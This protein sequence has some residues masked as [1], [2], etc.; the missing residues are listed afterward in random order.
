MIRL[1]TVKDS[2]EDLY[3]KFDRMMGNLEA[4]NQRVANL[5]APPQIEAN[6]PNSHN[7]HDRRG[8]RVRGHYRNFNNQRDNQ[9]RRHDDFLPRYSDEDTHEDQETPEDDSSRGGEQDNVWN[10]NEDARMR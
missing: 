9:K 10:C 8:P 1:L 6:I 5:S 3:D 2:F 7:F 4:L